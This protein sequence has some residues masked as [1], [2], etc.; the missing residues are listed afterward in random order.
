MQNVMQ[1]VAVD[2][3][4][5]IVVPLAGQVTCYHNSVMSFLCYQLLPDHRDLLAKWLEM[6]G[7]VT[8]NMLP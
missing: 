8:G 3:S 4:T 6:A 1:N 2:F 5:E 7:L